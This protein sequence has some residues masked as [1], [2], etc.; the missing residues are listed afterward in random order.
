DLGS[1]EVPSYVVATREDHI[2]PWRSA[3][4]PARLFGGPVRFVL[5]ASGHIAG[6][7]NHPDA[8]KYCH[9]TKARTAK[10]PEAW[11]KGATRHDGS[12]WPD[13]DKW[14]KRHAG[15]QDVAARIPGTGPLKAL[16]DA[17]GTYVKARAEESP[18]G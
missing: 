6:I 2:A 15:R 17:P 12:W 5:S 3:Y 14:V 4:A 11:L 16:A 9:W 13:W 1:I 10:T 7:I 18:I 8:G